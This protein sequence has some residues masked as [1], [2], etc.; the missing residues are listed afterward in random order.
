MN[1]DL[2][3]VDRRNFI[4]KIQLKIDYKGCFLQNILLSIGKMYKF[5]RI[6]NKKFV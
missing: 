2:R 3:I 6:N 5:V 4:E 1:R